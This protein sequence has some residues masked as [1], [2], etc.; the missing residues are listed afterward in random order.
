MQ[1]DDPVK[2]YKKEL[3][4]NMVKGLRKD[5]NA[6]REYKLKHPNDHQH[7]TITIS[8]LLVRLGYCWK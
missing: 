2:E 4:A 3:T 8:F 6:L 7:E 5:R 1:I